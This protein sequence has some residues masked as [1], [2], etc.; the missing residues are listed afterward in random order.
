MGRR[1]QLLLLITVRRLKVD[2]FTIFFSDFFTTLND[3]NFSQT[4]EMLWE[5]LSQTLRVLLNL[6]SCISVR[7]P[8]L[9]SLSSFHLSVAG[10]GTRVVMEWGKAVWL[11]GLP[12]LPS[13]PLCTPVPASKGTELQ[14]WAHRVSRAMGPCKGHKVTRDSISVTAQGEGWGSHVIVTW[15]LDPEGILFLR[16]WQNVGDNKGP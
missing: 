9:G 4:C 1:F 12:V 8:E 2:F 13:A 3:I 7:Q 10:E 5:N 15:E 16:M 14:R 11:S 6:K